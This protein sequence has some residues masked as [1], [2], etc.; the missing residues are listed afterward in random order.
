MRSTICNYELTS[1]LYQGPHAEVSAHCTRIKLLCE[2]PVT[3]IDSDDDVG[4]L[5]P[6]DLDGP[7]YVRDLEGRPQSVAA[8]PLDVS[9][10]CLACCFIMWAIFSSENKF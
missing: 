6:D 7:G 4:I 5:R 10:F 3:V 1:V 8:G 9:N 2:L